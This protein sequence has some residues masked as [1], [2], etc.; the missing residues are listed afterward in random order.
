MSLE[1]ASIGLA[2]I[3]GMLSILSP[4]VWPLVP[5][6][7]SSAATGGRSGPWLLAAGLS[8]SFALAGSVLTLVLLNLGLD[9]EILRYFAAAALS[10]VA[11]VLL[12]PAASQWV[13]LGLSRISGRFQPA[14]GAAGAGQFGVGVLLGLVWLP[15]VGPTLGAAIALASLGEELVMSFVVMFAFG[16]GTALTLLAAGNLTG[17]ALARW[18]PAV[19]RGA[20]RG[21]LALGVM[22]L[23]LGLM[24]LTG[25]DKKI[26]SATVSLIPDWAIS[27]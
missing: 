18:R 9:T 24:V 23:A 26:E 14:G 19:Q 6:V 20:A 4:C 22:L 15:C 25:V 16:A 11:I 5:V 12:I 1:I 7:M 27:L 8:V 13:T 10:V 3:A 2:L 21:K 17:R